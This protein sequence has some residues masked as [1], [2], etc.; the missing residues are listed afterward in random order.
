[1]PFGRVLD[2]NAA[3]VRP[4][5]RYVLYW[6]IGARRTE[7][8]FGL[9]RAVERSRELRRPLLVL[10]PLRVAYPFAS[11]RLHRFVLDGMRDN[12]A[13]FRAAGVTYH[14]Y[15]EPEP[16]AARGLLERLAADAC[17]VVTDDVPFFF[18][19]RMVRAAALRLPL[20]LEQVDGNGLLPLRQAQR[21]YPTAH[22]FRALVQRELP[23]QLSGFPAADPLAGYAPPRRAGLPADVRRRWPAAAPGLL[24]GRLDLAS[25][26]IDHRVSPAPVRGGPTAARAALRAFLDRL[27]DYEQDRNHPDRD[28]TSGLSP[29]LHF[30]HLSPHAV[31]AAVMIREG[32]HDGHLGRPAGGAR[33]GW[34]GVGPSTE[35]FLDQL[36]TW[37]ELGLN[38]CVFDESS[39]RWE[40]LPAWARATLA[41][42]ARDRR[43]HR[44]AVEELERAATHDRLWNAAQTQLLREGRLHN[45]LR[46][47]WGKRILEWSATPQDALV[48]MLRLND[49]WALDGRDANSISGITWVLGRYDRPWGPERPIFG[50]VRYMS[51]ENTA[52]KLRVREYLAR[53]AS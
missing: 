8:S 18:L 16:G 29:Y 47:L 25:L 43:P 52:R 23:A 7:W 44:Y 48:A 42:H 28:A 11:D 40:S 37:R 32:W 21:A 10:E 12:A 51:S 46:M 39:A 20:R 6:M 31:F 19:P 36:V 2:A 22:S 14:P 38:R 30:G 45:Y 17:L 9:Q 24:D 1:M 53:Y 34:W 15:V 50:T 41:A 4:D 13:R 5:G 26:P 33:T 49:R 27:D 3:P 35:A